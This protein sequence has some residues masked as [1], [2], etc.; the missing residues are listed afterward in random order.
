MRKMKISIAVVICIVI[1]VV[2]VMA[3]RPTVIM[4]FDDGWLSVYD[5][6]YPIMQLNDQKG[7]DFVYITPIIGGYLDFMQQPQL[8]TLY[9]AGWDISSHTYS[10][11][12][13]TTVNNTTLNYELGTSKDWL[14]VNGYP[15]GAM[16]LAYPEGAYNQAVID[17]VKANN[18]AAARTVES[19]NGTYL[20]Y[21]LNSIDIFTLKS[22]ETVGGLDNDTTV[23]EQINNT[24]AAN[25]SLILVFHKIVDNLSPTAMETEFRT[26]D[27]QNVSN[28]LK[29]RSLDVDVRTL[30]DYFGTVPLVIYI[31]P[32]PINMTSK[33]GID[34]NG[35]NWI[36]VSWLP[37]KGVKTDLYNVNVNGL[38]YNNI[39][40]TYINI[41]PAIPNILYDIKV[42]AIN[43]TNGT[44]V[45]QTP[46]TIQTLIPLY[47]P[48]IPIEISQ[49]SGNSGNSGNFWAYFKWR[50][51]TV[52]NVTSNVTDLFNYSVNGLW[53]NLSTNTSVNVSTVPH[54]NVTVLVYAYNN[55]NGG[56]QSV[57]P[58]EMKI[59][60]ENNVI[61]IGN[62][63]AEYDIYA[64]D[65]LRIVP[66]VYNP[67]NDTIRFTTNATK[68]SI[69]NTTGA[70]ILNTSSGDEGIYHWNITGYDDQ[71]P[72]HIIDFIVSII[73]KPVQHNSDGGSGNSGGSGGA[74]NVYDPNIEYYE[75]R[76]S[77]IHNGFESVIMFTKNK[78]ITNVTFQG[79]RNY[80]VVTTKASIFKACPTTN[81]LND[82]YKFFSITLDTI[83]QK[84]EYLY[85]SNASV[86]I[87]INKSDLNDNIIKAYR[88]V[89]DSWESLEI[90]D[91][92][93]EDNET[94]QFK[95]KSNGLSKFALV[96]EPQKSQI[97]KN[98]MMENSVILAGHEMIDDTIEQ[99]SE[100]R[101]SLYRYIINLI[102][103]YMP[104]I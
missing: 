56:V 55:T 85:I 86:T 65:T 51:G 87:A 14:N 60:I 96:L 100:V 101:E 12:I 38:L 11:T 45:N 98:I 71:G 62:I 74:I 63:W 24:I 93:I 102:K 75:L 76:D 59:Q 104:W 81:C 8:N 16:F 94:K 30:S 66:T 73:R 27:F 99:V 68:A 19:P 35:N 13:L 22:Y 84:H 18:Y 1:L 46:A 47:V 7:V 4:T 23:I 64:G 57:S 15:R 61:E 33:I 28:Y 42:N 40:N 97:D 41:T 88:Y 90:E 58:L 78:F 5:K 17:A 3:E 37:G 6:A 52:E 29:N 2:P 44:T 53:T 49:S 89:N 70:F 50:N 43:T 69:N 83:P 21:N 9:G 95:L 32:T 67:D 77:Q 92:H 34:V 48:P 26:S 80:G 103:K 54:G 25:G 82:V 10:H 91:M 20:Q 31:P 39:A 79:I 72:P 36:N